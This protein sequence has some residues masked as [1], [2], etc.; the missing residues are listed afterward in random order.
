MCF[1]IHPMQK[2]LSSPLP[3]ISTNFK[4][5]TNSSLLSSSSLKKLWKLFSIRS[6]N[7]LNNTL[8]H[9]WIKSVTFRGWRIALISTLSSLFSVV[10][11][12]QWENSFSVTPKNS[13]ES[14]LTETA[15]VPCF[16][17]SW[18]SVLSEAQDYKTL[19]YHSYK[20]YKC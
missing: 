6:V 3:F 19:V 2:L 20:S 5:W 9:W 10:C 14:K 17:D 1:W 12:K 15:S 16:S 13:M 7:V 4:C 11:D 18:V 8:I